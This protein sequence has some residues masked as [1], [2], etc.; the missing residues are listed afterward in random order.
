[1]WE[2]SSGK[3]PFA[4]FENDFDLVTRILDGMRPKIISG[5]PLEYIR[6]MKQCWNANTTERFTTESIKKEIKRMFQDTPNEL[7]NNEKIKILSFDICHESVTS[8]IHQSEGLSEPKNATE[9]EQEAF[10]SKPYDFSIPQNI[11]DWNRSESSDES[12]NST[13]KS[14]YNTYNYHFILHIIKG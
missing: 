8:K 13:S 1:M 3:R 10:H 2:I 9:E 6:I 5:T 14:F 11:E 7:N 12:N 4:N